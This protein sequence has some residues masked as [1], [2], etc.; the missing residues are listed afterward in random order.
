MNR[1]KFLASSA[2]ATLVP[3]A[4]A[5]TRAEV[6]DQ[7]F[8]PL[9]RHMLNMNFINGTATYAFINH[10]LEG[11]GVAGPYSSDFNS[12]SIPW[13]HLIDST[14]GWPNNARVD[15]RRWGVS[16]KFP[17]PSNFAGPYII[18]WE[19]D[20]QLVAQ[21]GTWTETN[22]ND[23]YVRN[24]NGNWTNV[25]G[26]SARIIANVTGFSGPALIAFTFNASGGLG[27]FPRN[28][29]IYRLADE[30]DML[31]GNVFRSAFKQ[32]IVNSGCGAVRTMNWLGGV[33]VHEYRFE[34]R[35]LP[36]SPGYGVGANWTASP[37]YSDASVS[38]SLMTVAA[39][40]TGLKQ[41]PASMMHG[42]IATFR[43]LSTPPARNGKIAVSSISNGPIPSVHAPKHGFV[44]GDRVIHSTSSGM[45]ELDRV[46]VTV[47]VVDAD[48]YTITNFDTTSAG[49]FTKGFAC[50][51]I[52]LQ[53]GSGNDRTTYPVV[54][55]GVE[56]AGT[57][58][59][60][61][62]RY[63]YNTYYFDKNVN[64]YG[65]GTGGYHR[66]AWV[67]NNLF[68]GTHWGG[69][70][71]EI[72]SKLIIE[73][74]AL[75]PKPIHLYVCFPYKGL[76]SVDPDYSAGSNF[77]A[78]G[79]DVLW[80][81]A[82]GY[83]GIK[84]GAPNAMIFVECGNEW[85]N[86]GTEN[87]QYNAWAA[88]SRW[89]AAGRTLFCDWQMLRAVTQARDIRAR[90]LTD[91]RIK[92]VFGLWAAVGMSRGGFGANYEK[93]FGSSTP[94]TAGYFYATD[95]IVVANRW[96]APL[97][98]LDAWAIA[99][100]I[101][102]GASYETGSGFNTFTDDSAMYNGTDNSANGGGN[103]ND[104][105]NPAR[106]IKNLVNALSVS[107]RGSP[108][109]GIADWITIHRQYLSYMPSGKYLLNYEG[110]FDTSVVTGRTM[111]GGHVITARDHVFLT[112]ALTSSNWGAALSNFMTRLC[113]LSQQFGLPAAYLSVGFGV[114]GANDMRWSFAAPDSYAGG[115][116]GQALLNNGSW[117][118]LANRN[119]ALP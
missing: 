1:R 16:A 96:G 58:G 104:A 87:A 115:T 36:S 20:G 98:E 80:D 39:V 5:D 75:S 108:G 18:T 97:T 72:I 69:C 94:G 106:A 102:L 15:G 31:A 59:N 103:Y 88:F 46:P 68:G 85:W 25:F 12:V 11:D 73:L 83:P 9:Q 37:R 81:G 76:L 101:Y 78:N 30:A 54:F 40:T 51:D 91:P 56:P 10:V 42:E 27:G 33:N 116:E 92:H 117:V 23:S 114:S 41:T 8:P 118:A 53:V 52:G 32:Q 99:P 86:F 90:G 17:D 82:N 63:V 19:G 22:N 107:T 62:Q 13:T 14:T 105:A 6:R 28:V 26:K 24:G 74:N 48:N 100:Y 29:K 60:Y 57:F 112:A 79:L 55:G 119:R 34:H 49:A 67:F 70:P 2:L 47:H 35:Q 64:G 4:P 77:A 84:S 110:N 89:S 43:P 113:S 95:S 38:G 111:D 7:L 109:P 50:I 71:L 66:G 45:T 93:I 21:L 65:D 61:I 3:L 44:E